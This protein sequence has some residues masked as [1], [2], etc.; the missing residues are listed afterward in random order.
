MGGMKGMG[1]LGLFIREFFFCF[2]SFGQDIDR[3][4]TRGASGIGGVI[5]GPLPSRVA[6]NKAM[7]FTFGREGFFGYASSG[8]ASANSLMWWS[9]FETDSLPSRTTKLD[10]EEIKAELKKRHG[11]AADPVVRDII[12]K[13]EVE[14]IYPTWVMPDLPHWGENGIVLIGDAAHALSPTTGQGAS[15]ALE[16][17][18]TLSLLLAE[19][20]K[21]AYEPA[22][23]DSHETL[24]GKEKAAIAL[25]LKLLYE[26]RH[27]RVK[28]IGERG[29]KMDKGKRKM[30]VVEE[31]A[32]YCFLKVMMSFI[33]IGEFDCDS[34]AVHVLSQLTR[35]VL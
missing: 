8:P 25:T 20:L 18:Q 1:S 5:H 31:Y 7:V 21:K 29:R 33:F 6:D 24:A 22:D 30:G 2:F 23:G 26:I 12:S 9:T 13:A 11:G 14:S 34:C 3:R 19:T 15:Q 32:M 28:A 17:A 10:T 4:S 35:F 27:D 16:D